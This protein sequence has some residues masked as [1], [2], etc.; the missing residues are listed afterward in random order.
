MTAVRIAAQIMDAEDRAEMMAQHISTII[1]DGIDTAELIQVAAEV[2]EELEIIDEAV[3]SEWRALVRASC[4]Q[5]G[6]RITPEPVMTTTHYTDGTEH[7]DA[8]YEMYRFCYQQSRLAEKHYEL[9]VRA[10]GHDDHATRL[11]AT[12]SHYTRNC[13]RLD[14]MVQIER[15]ARINGRTVAEQ[16]A[17]EKAAKAAQKVGT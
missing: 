9:Y 3:T 13:A 6:T 1:G 7:Y 4:V 17:A 16:I 2:A 12:V 10:H 11:R 14:E 15:A 8:T 5:V